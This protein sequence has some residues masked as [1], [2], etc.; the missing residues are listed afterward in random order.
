MENARAG[1]PTLPHNQTI[2]RLFKQK[3]LQQH[4]DHVLKMIIIIVSTIVGLASW[5]MLGLNGDINT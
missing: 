1:R 2:S 3:P 4:R 5:K